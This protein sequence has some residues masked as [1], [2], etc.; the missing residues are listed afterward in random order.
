MDKSFVVYD[1]LN[2]VA[3]YC[4]PLVRFY[5]DNSDY[6]VYY[7]PDG[8]SKCRIFTSKLIKSASG[9]F[10]I[11][12]IT[13][14][15][16]SRLSNIPYSIVVSLPTSFS[17]GDDINKFF[18]D[19]SSNFG[20]TFSSEI[21]KLSDQ[22][23]CPNS[24]FANSDL[25]Y[26]NDVIS[27][28]NVSLSKLNKLSSSSFVWELPNSSYENKNAG[29]INSNFS[30]N[31]ILGSDN[32]DFS[33]NTNNFNN[34]SLGLGNIDSIVP[35][36]DIAL[37]SNLNSN[38]ISDSNSYSSL[39]SYNYQLPVN[40]VDFS[41]KP[42]ISSSSVFN[43]SSS[44]SYNTPVFN[45]QGIPSGGDVSQ[46]ESNN[47]RVLKKNAGF[48]SNSYII[49]GTVCLILAAIV[50]GVSIVIVKNL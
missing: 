23:L 38:I 50:V 27:F 8:N 13:D 2:S 46:L 15:E 7:L 49:I 14:N 40:S 48:A 20:I 18:S 19:F 43:H 44:Y 6:L 12:D 10:L 39:N 21:P 29:T 45:S 9:N 28:Y 35:I 34:Q 22:L 3:F 4:Y 24:F 11:H 16:K 32:F 25:D 26:I 17:S 41:G 37:D 42:N 33:Y 5:F 47:V 1:K 30:S 31:T 36:N